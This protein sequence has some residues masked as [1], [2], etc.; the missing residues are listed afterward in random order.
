MFI[1]KFGSRLHR[2][3]KQN[4]GP[5]TSPV[6]INRVML[7]TTV[8]NWLARHCV[9]KSQTHRDAKDIRCSTT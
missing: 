7:T 4:V 1:I 6:K 9:F 8:S 2:Q 5:E 3:V